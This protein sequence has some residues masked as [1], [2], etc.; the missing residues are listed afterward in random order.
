[1]ILPPLRTRTH[2]PR[3]SSLPIDGHPASEITGQNTEQNTEQN[4]GQ[5]TEQHA[6]QNAEQNAEQISAQND[7]LE[8]GT[9]A[10]GNQSR[11]SKTANQAHRE[12]P[13]PH[14]ARS[15]PS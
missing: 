14:L 6:E 1:M 12:N 15:G 7:A 11:T 8:G 13:T 4:A 10:P 9:H 2:P 3:T 5:N